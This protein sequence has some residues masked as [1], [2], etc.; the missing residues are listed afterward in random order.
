MK[1][2]AALLI[3][4]SLFSCKESNTIEITTIDVPTDTT[5]KIMTS[6]VGNP[7]PTTV[8]SGVI[9]DGKLSLDNPFTELE[10]A[11]L[12]FNDDMQS[13]VFF[14]GEPGHITISYTQDKPLETAIGGSENNVKLQSLQNEA[15]P[16]VEKLRNFIDANQMSLMT[17]SQSNNEEDQK[18]FE[19]LKNEYTDMVDSI[20][21]I[22]EKYQKENSD[23]AFGL[24]LLSQQLMSSAGGEKDFSA[25]FAKFPENLK[26]SKVGVKVNTLLEMMSLSE[27]DDDDSGVSVGE[28]AP[29]FT[30]KTPDGKE[31]SLNQFIK[32]KKLVLID[33]WASWCG[34]CRIENPNV[35]KLYNDFNGK[36]LDIIGV[37]LDK[38]KDKWVQ[39]IEKDNLKWQQVSNLQYWDDVIAKSYGVQAIPANYLIDEDGTI[40]AKNL[41][42]E[43]LHNKV[44]ELLK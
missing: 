43:E 17:L 13:N 14:I 29:D 16:I 11:Y 15:K 23:N 26:T 31:V 20:N 39:A 25:E 21:A 4:L 42:G 18:K 35:V 41:Y 37:S 8:A 9:K 40:L 19:A 33:F 30:S 44:A 28:I 10:E 32:G 34:P 3:A 24:L 36:G 2:F 12:V 5:V 22:Y 6:E 27:G 1:K 38:D 7:E